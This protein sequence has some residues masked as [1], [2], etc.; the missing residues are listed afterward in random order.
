M[1]K[2]KMLATLF[3]LI[4]FA[5]A[6]ASALTH[7]QANDECRMVWRPHAM[8]LEPHKLPLVLPDLPSLLG[9]QLLFDHYLRF[10][11]VR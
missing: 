10:E 5:P 6:P 11:G 1:T 4:V 9:R 3:G 2:F 7:D 8:E